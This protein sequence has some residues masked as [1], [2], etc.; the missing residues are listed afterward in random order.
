ME[1]AVD[2]EDEHPAVGAHQPRVEIP[3]PARCVTAGYLLGRSREPGLSTD[4]DEVDL[5]QRVAAALD[6]LEHPAH[7]RAVPDRP[8]LAQHVAECGHRGD[9][10]LDGGTQHRGSLTGVRLPR[11]RIDHRPLGT[12][13]PWR[14]ARVD[15]GLGEPPGLVDLDPRQGVHPAATRDDDVYLFRQPAG[16][17]S[18]LGRSQRGQ[19]GA[20]AHMDHRDPPPLPIGEW[21]TVQHDR[22]S[23]QSPT[24]RSYLVAN[25]VTVDTQLQQL[26]PRDDVVL[27]G[28]EHSE[29]GELV[30][31]CEHAREHDPGHRPTRPRIHRSNLSGGARGYPRAMPDS[32]EWGGA[33]GGARRASSASDPSP[34]SRRAAPTPARPTLSRRHQPCAGLRWSLRR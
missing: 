27:C 2:L 28:C 7:D 14:P 18:S 22:T 9:P 34:A 12:T 6:V 24:P 26:R 20:L 5:G 23:D 31:G 16:K 4:P 10:L 19:C 25:H 13:L 30:A 21:A 3:L 33:S 29:C 17:P 1:G 8:R 32:S 11:R 15:V